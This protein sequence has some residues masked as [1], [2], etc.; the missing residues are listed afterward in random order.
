MTSHK[1]HDEVPLETCDG[2]HA[3]KDVPRDHPHAT[4]IEWCRRMGIF[5]GFGDGTFRP[6][7]AIT[8]GQLATALYR[9][10]GK[11]LEAAMRR[12]LTA[13]QQS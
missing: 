5:H 12:V 3:F 2:D 1:T 6:H 4:G 9:L 10:S 13:D 7:K 8:R 11:E